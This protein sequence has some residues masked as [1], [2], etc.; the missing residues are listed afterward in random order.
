MLKK[1]LIHTN[2]DVVCLNYNVA[3]RVAKRLVSL[4]IEEGREAIFINPYGSLFSQALRILRTNEGI[5][6]PTQADL[7]LDCARDYE[8]RKDLL[9]SI[10][11]GTSKILVS[12]TSPSLEATFT[13]LT[14]RRDVSKVFT[15][16]L[17]KKLLHKPD[18]VAYLNIDYIIE[19]KSMYKRKIELNMKGTETQMR[20]KYYPETLKVLKESIGCNYSI[21]DVEDLSDIESLARQCL[22]YFKEGRGEQE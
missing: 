22:Y 16:Y 17:V 1:K 19:S 9:E 7:L 4:L 18:Y 21:I 5:E 12:P 8:T 2:I 15:R 11:E 3:K 14:F 6:I 10:R 20:G 13:T